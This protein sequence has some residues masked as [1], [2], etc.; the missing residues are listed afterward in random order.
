MKSWRI[1]MIFNTKYKL[2]GCE[3]RTSPPLK[4][5]TISCSF[6]IF[7]ILFSFILFFYSH[8]DEGKSYQYISHV[9]FASFFSF[10]L[11]LLSWLAR[12]TV[13][14]QR[15]LISWIADDGGWLYDWN[16]N[17][18]GNVQNDWR[19]P[20]Q[21]LSGIH[22]THFSAARLALPIWIAW[23]HS[24]HFPCRIFLIYFLFQ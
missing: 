19:T 13:Q 24:I 15:Q 4:T 5:V 12:W 14:C 1:S 21:H 11:F 3:M 8:F 16:R 22:I 17:P 2:D 23:C 10:I 7:F 20:S 18:I 6:I 9:L